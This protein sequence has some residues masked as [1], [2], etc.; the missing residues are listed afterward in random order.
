MNL[1][2]FQDAVPGN[3]RTGATETF[4]FAST[5]SA[6]WYSLL[7]VESGKITRLGFTSAKGQK[8]RLLAALQ[9]VGTQEHLLLGV[10]TGSHRTALFVLD[11][12][13]AIRELGKLPEPR[14]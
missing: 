13:V 5:D 7:V 10:W 11:S 2:D 12:A 14:S 9:A 8:K 3:Y 1:T 4:P 6:I